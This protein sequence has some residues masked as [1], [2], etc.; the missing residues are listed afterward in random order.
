MTRSRLRSPTSKSTTTTRFPSRASAAPSAAVDV[1]LPTPPLPDVTT[2][3][4]AIHRSFSVSVDCLDFQRVAFQPGVNR[5]VAEVRFDLIGYAVVPVYRH[6][7]RFQP[8][9]EN[10][11]ATVPIGA[12]QGSS[13]QG[14][15]D[16]DR[17]RRDDFRARGQ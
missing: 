5:F 14:S 3:T 11:S 13:A 16:V 10:P 17:S 4:W 1:V 7:F 15:V 9:A 12:G 2:R 6:E 8:A